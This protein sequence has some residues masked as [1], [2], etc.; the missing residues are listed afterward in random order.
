M[1]YSINSRKLVHSYPIRISS[2]SDAVTGLLEM[3]LKFDYFLLRNRTCFAKI[4]P[5][6]EHF[7]PCIG[8]T[9]P[10]TQLSS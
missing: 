9:Y 3:D 8:S 7:R 1:Q 6:S 10:Y 4:R 2:F 5:I